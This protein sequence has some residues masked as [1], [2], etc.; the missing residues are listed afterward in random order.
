MQS[1]ESKVKAALKV[2]LDN[3]LNVCGTILRKTRTHW[4]VESDD[5]QLLSSWDVAGALSEVGAYYADK[6]LAIGS[7]QSAETRKWKLGID[8]ISE[9]EYQLC[10]HPKLPG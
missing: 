10:F 8:R 9:E 1:K 7:K 2:L 4:I 5:P 6:G 3:E